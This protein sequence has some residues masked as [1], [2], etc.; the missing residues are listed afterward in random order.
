MCWR[1]LKG[2][3]P[4]RVMDVAEARVAGVMD[5]AEARVARVA[6]VAVGEAA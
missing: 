2:K 3:V 1:G 6:E 4:V 5:V